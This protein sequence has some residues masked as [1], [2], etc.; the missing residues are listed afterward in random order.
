MKVCIHTKT[1]TQIFTAALF[2]I[3]EQPKYLS[4]NKMWYSH[5]MEYYLAMER[6]VPIHAITRMDLDNIML[7]EAS[8][9]PR[10]TYCTI[11]FM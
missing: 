5:I 7:N 4:A 3:L 8:Q 6:N 11:P 10:T 1:C 2:I 9:T